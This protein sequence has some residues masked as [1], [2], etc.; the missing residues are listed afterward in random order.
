MLW[1]F[2]RSRRLRLVPMGSVALAAGLIA[3]A[4]LPATALAAPQADPMYAHDDS[5]EGDRGF[6]ETFTIKAGATI[7]VPAYSPTDPVTHPG[8]VQ[9]QAN[10]ITIEKGAAIVADGSGYPGV[11]GM[12]GLCF[13][14]KGCAGAGAMSGDPGGGGGYFGNGAN[15]TS[16]MTAG[17]CVDLGVSATGGAS[18][19]LIPQDAG[20]PLGSAGGASN[21][22]GMVLATAGGAGGGGIRLSAGKIVID[23]TLSA[24]GAPSPNMFNGVAP[25]AGS[26]G[27]IV[28]FAGVLTGTGTLSVTGGDGVA[29]TGISGS[30]PPNNGGGGSGGVIVV[31]LPSGAPAPSVTFELGGGKTGDCP[32]TMNGQ[33]GNEAQTPLPNGATCV[34][35]DGDGFTSTACGGK[36]CDDVDPTVHPGVMEICNGKD[37]N[38]NGQIDE[39]PNDCTKQ[40]LVC[41]N[42]SC[43]APPPDG[44]T[45]DGGPDLGD[46][47]LDHIDYTGGCTVSDALPGSGGSALA[48]G[49]AVMALAAS[50]RRRAG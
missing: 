36:D 25:G 42:A 8:Y 38:C 34:D 17:T 45:E 26:G 43:V 47:G 1:S 5:L 19:Q 46:A 13:P 10:V 7:T 50:R 32:T 18:F 48:L 24:N 6:Y 37:D 27:T 2:R 9:I 16:E 23:G 12:N 15:G 22:G 49:V 35:L 39:A 40:G 14:M 41:M 28:L 11:A 21:Y 29:A 33:A 3:T 31:Q 44:G 20:V 4:L 30:Y